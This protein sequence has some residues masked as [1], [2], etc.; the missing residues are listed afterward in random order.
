MKEI[1]LALWEIFSA[2]MTY[3]IIM[4]TVFMLYIVYLYI[5]HKDDKPKNK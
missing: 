5:K 4:F 1:L 3:F 2:F